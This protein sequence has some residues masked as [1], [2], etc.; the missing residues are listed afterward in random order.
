MKLYEKMRP[1]ENLGWCR[2]YKSDRITFVL[3]E[4]DITTIRVDGVDHFAPFSADFLREVARAAVKDY[5]E[6]EYEDYSVEELSE[7]LICRSVCEECGC[8]EC[9]YRDDCDAVGFDVEE[10]E[11][12]DAE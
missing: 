2:C 9:P 5:D 12:E 6:D 4:G 7:L 8:R 1:D 11:N 10:G 3:T